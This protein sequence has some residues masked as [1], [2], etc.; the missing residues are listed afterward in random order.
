MDV[1]I[2][3]NPRELIDEIGKDIDLQ[4]SGHSRGHPRVNI[5]VYYAKPKLETIELFW[6][7]REFV[8]RYSNAGFL[9]DQRILDAFLQNHDKFDP[10]M[11]QAWRANPSVT[12][13]PSKVK[14]ARS[15]AL[16][17]QQHVM[18]NPNAVS[19]FEE[20]Y[21]NYDRPKSYYH[22]EQR[23]VSVKMPAKAGRGTWLLA[24]RNLLGSAEALGRQSIWSDT[25]RGQFCFSLSDYRYHAP[26]QLL[27]YA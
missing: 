18:T 27:P 1:A 10:D 2:A 7:C 3:K 9:T 26:R 6:N 16:Y 15:S 24:L 11:L 12:W 17:S 14:W 19:L 8:M 20:T 23:Y 25:G 22:P 21:M 4:L 13:P 5:G